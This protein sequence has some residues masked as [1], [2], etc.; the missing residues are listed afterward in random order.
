MKKKKKFVKPNR[1]TNTGLVKNRR[2]VNWRI[3]GTKRLLN[4]GEA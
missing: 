3:Q 2:E 1:V 4:Q